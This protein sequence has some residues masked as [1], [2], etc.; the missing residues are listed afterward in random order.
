MVKNLPADA[1][2]TGDTVSTPGLGKT[3]GGGNGNPLQYSCWENPMEM[4]NTLI[5]PKQ[6][7]CL[8]VLLFELQIIVSR[9]PLYFSETCFLLKINIISMMFLIF[10]QVSIQRCSSFI[11]FAINIC[12]TYIQWTFQLFLVVCFPTDAAVHMSFGAYGPKISEENYGVK[13]ILWLQDNVSSF[14]K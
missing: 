9:C 3:P 6:H 10:I 7:N 5:I 2:D 8:V 14:P 1:R 4:Y 11:I 13:V 12:L